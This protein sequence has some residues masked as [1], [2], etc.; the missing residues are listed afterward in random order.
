LID[1]GLHKLVEDV[2]RSS[3]ERR[4]SE[5]YTKRIAFKHL[6]RFLQE[7]PGIHKYGNQNY[8]HAIDR[9]WKQIYRDLED[10]YSQ[11]YDSITQ[12]SLTKWIN[13]LIRDNTQP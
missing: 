3:S 13:L 10:Y 7:L 4:S 12:D 8:E 1:L 9:T 11:K 2:Y 5:Q 6:L